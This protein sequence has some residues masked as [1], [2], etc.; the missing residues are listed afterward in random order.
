MICLIHCIK[1]LQELYYIDHTSTKSFYAFIPYRI[2]IPYDIFY[3][4][5][6]S[7]DNKRM[8]NNLVKL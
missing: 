2:P 1:T 6:S 4:L 7:I 8:Y 5:L 3:I